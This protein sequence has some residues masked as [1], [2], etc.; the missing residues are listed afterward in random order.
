MGI[1]P[2]QMCF[3]L[4]EELDRQSFACF[5]ETA[6]KKDFAET[7]AARLSSEEILEL[8]DAF[9]G[10]LRRHLSEDEYH[11]LFLGDTSPH[12]HKHED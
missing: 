1:T 9:T 7:L 5:L 4:S 10:L 11:R 8:V 2:D 3:G 12:H 6:G